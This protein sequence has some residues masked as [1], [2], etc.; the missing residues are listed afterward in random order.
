M[1][2]INTIIL[3]FVLRQLIKKKVFL[4]IAFLNKFRSVCE[5][6]NAGVHM[7]L[8]WFTPLRTDS[9]SHFFFNPG[10]LIDLV[11]VKCVFMEFLA[12]KVTCGSIRSLIYIRYFQYTNQVT[13]FLSFSSQL[14]VL[15]AFFNHIKKILGYCRTY[16]IPN[17]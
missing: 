15:L 10:D 14:V 6:K 7:R 8:V 2:R 17:I 5:W 4:I 13:K 16:K 1:K 9:Q 3:T 11:Y 12:E